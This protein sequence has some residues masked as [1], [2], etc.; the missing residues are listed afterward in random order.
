MSKY[1]LCPECGESI[2]ININN[3]K[4]SLFNCKNAHKLNI[5]LFD[6]F[7]A[8]TKKGDFK[9]DYFCNKH[10]KQYNKYCNNCKINICELCVKE[11]SNH[12]IIN[13]E[14]I[15]FNINDIINQK[16]ELKKSID[17]F[18]KDVKVIKEKNDEGN[19]L[20][21][22]FEIYF[23]LF[24]KIINNYIKKS[25]DY[26]TIQNLIEFKKYNQQ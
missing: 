22:N 11:H 8:L 4:I 20:S 23:N 19:K 3:Y 2:F 1:I 26:Q 15:I 10:N 24:D 12:E 14:D 18:N 25:I 21:E 16:N 17:E 6:E 5:I 13:Y 7:E 9:I